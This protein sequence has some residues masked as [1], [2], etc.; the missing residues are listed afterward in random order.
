M[1]KKNQV[2]KEKKPNIPI[3]KDLVV[4][5]K[6]F[7][8]LILI[9]IILSFG[10]VVIFL[11]GPMM[12]REIIDLLMGGIFGNPELGIAPGT[13]TFADILR[14][15]ITLIILYLILFL[16]GYIQQFIMATVTTKYAKNLR[17]KMKNKTDRL[18]LSYLDGETTGD[19]LS[20]ITNDI[21]TLTDSL[22]WAVMLLISAIAL[23]LGA[24]GFMVFYNWQMGLTSIGASIIGFVIMML[25]LGIAQKHMN[26]QQ[27][28][29]GLINGHIEEYFTGHTVLKVCN[30]QK[31][32]SQK[33][34][35]LNEDLYKSGWKAQ[36]FS[37]LLMPLIMFVNNFSLVAVAVVGGVLVFNG[38]VTFGVITMFIIYIQLFNGSITDFA[39]GMMNVAQLKAAGVRVFTLLKQP[40]MENES[41]FQDYFNIDGSKPSLISPKG[42]FILQNVKFGYTESEVIKDLSLDIKPG[43]KIAIVGPTGAGKTTIINL[44]MKFYNVQNGDIL[45]DGISIKNIKR[46]EIAQLFSM[47]LQDTWTFNGTFR[48]NLIYNLNIQKDKENELL[49]YAT[50]IT[51]IYDYIMKQKDGFDTKFDGEKGLSSGQKQLLTIARAIIKDSPFLILD[52]ATSS[53]DTQTEKFVKESMDKLAENKTS[54][55]IAHRLSTIKNADLILVLNEGDVIE[56]G[57]HEELL[58]LKGF[59]AN[60]YNSQFSE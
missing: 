25:I 42:E 43:S 53:V 12:V 60:L 23:I 18:P 29:I 19:V 21:T 22:G 36:W 26:K 48:E 41:D 14:I 2:K 4:S 54:F 57:K 20:K 24:G 7:W 5:L 32:V 28:E 38:S 56:T 55:I 50:K 59:Y 17:T 46:S 47:V 45:I 31:L 13:N 35:K 33:F 34:D 37:G 27:T 58:E 30:A 6:S 44:L 15:S 16:L 1:K 3:F 51:G 10:G 52:E 9:A 11:I 39:Q 49:T 40:E 8:P